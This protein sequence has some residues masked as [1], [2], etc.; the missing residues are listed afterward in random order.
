MGLLGNNHSN[1]GLQAKLHLVNYPKCLNNNFFGPYQICSFMML[2]FFFC[3]LD[4]LLWKQL[5][6]LSHSLSHSIRDHCRHINSSFLSQSQ[7][8]FLAELRI[9]RFEFVGSSSCNLES[10]FWACLNLTWKFPKF[11]LFQQVKCSPHCFTS[12]RTCWFWPIT[13]LSP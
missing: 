10:Q 5:E 13:V 1:N 12:C 9:Y 6:F 2:F 11:V 4:A 7:I 3:L 8:S